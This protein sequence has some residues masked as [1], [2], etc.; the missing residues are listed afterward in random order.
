MSKIGNNS[1]ITVLYADK[2]TYKQAEKIRDLIF[3]AE[4]GLP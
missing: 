1:S 3:M 4:V 2:S